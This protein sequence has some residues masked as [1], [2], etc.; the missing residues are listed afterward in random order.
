[1]LTAEI[2]INVLPID[3]PYAWEADGLKIVL[4]RTA[5][6]VY[7]FQDVCPHASWPLSAGTFHDGK[8]ECPGH[9]WEFRVETG[10]CPESPTYCLTRVSA[11]VEGEMVRL[12]WK[13]ESI[14]QETE[15]RCSQMQECA[16]RAGN[17]LAEP[18][19]SR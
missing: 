10:E 11:R 14:S 1:M 4:L 3:K 17:P 15:H 12:E 9:G 16:L 2:P 7:A 18:Q 5:E 6:R 19:R 13:V 8:L